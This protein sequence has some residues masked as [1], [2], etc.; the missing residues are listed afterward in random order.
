MAALPQ[1]VHATA[2][3]ALLVGATGLVGRSLLPL[4]LEGDAYARVTVLARSARASTSPRLDWHAVD[5]DRLPS[6]FPA[7]DDVYVALGTTIA[8]AGS[9]AAFR[10]VDH[11]I[12]VGVARAARA[13]GAQRLGVVSAL[14]ADPRSRVFYNRV[15]GEMEEA[16]SGLGYHAVVIAQPSLLVGD[17]AALGQ[18]VRLGEVVAARLLAPVT[19][20]VPRAIRP[21]AAA[22][23]ARALVHAVQS[24]APGVRRLTS[25][26]MQ[27]YAPS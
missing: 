6:L 24:A 17:R 23:V 25:A 14:G 21:I 13:A 22:S 4:L 16:V 5:F 26:Q 20:L 11:D 8:A 2:P 18:P 10:H 15:K 7:V 19:R 27:A 12:V 3:R 1:T 9:Q